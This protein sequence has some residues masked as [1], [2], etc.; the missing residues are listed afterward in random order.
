[1]LILIKT[2]TTTVVSLDLF[3]VFVLPI[4][5]TVRACSLHNFSVLSPGPV[6]AFEVVGY[7]LVCSA[8]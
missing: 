1:M 6:F 3:I 5:S 7:Q 2:V 4:V 8:K